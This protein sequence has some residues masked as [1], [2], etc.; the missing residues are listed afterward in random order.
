VAAKFCTKCRAQVGEFFKTCPYD[1]AELKLIPPAPIVGQ[2]F[3]ERYEILSILGE[4]GMSI[5]YKARHRFMERIVAIKLLR[6]TM[7]SDAL[8]LERFRQEA[9]AV[10]LLN[11]PNIVSVYDFGIVDD[12]QPFLVMDYLDGT[13]LA[14]VLGTEG[15]LTE[16]R[17]V[18][19]FR[20]ICEGLRHAHEK[21][22]VHRDL[23][24]TNICLVQ[25]EKKHEVAKIVD[26]GVAKMIHQD[27]TERMQLTQTGQVVGSPLFMSPEQC[28]AKSL[29]ARSDIYSLGCVMYFTLTGEFPIS[30]ITEFDAMS[31]HIHETPK[32]FKL[33][34]SQLSLDQNL[35]A[36][37]F[38]CLEKQPEDRYQSVSELLADLPEV[39]PDT[40]SLA[41]KAVEHPLRT[42]LRFRIFRWGFF[43]L[44]G[45]VSAVLLYGLNDQ[46]PEIDKGSVLQKTIWNSKTTWGQVLIDNKAWGPAQWVLANAEKQ[47]RD[48]FPNHSRL[49]TALKLQ[50]ELYKKARMFEEY[51]VVS[52]EIAKLLE[53]FVREDYTN[54]MGEID[55]LE[56]GQSEAVNRVLAEYSAQNVIHAAKEL[57]GYHLD[58]KEE[59]LLNRAKDVYSK[60]LGPRHRLIAEFDT[61]LADCHLR[62][63]E[64]Y[65]VRPLLVEARSIYADAKGNNDKSTIAATLRLGQFDR[66]EN[67]FD[68]AKVEL[69]TALAKAKKYYPGNTPD[70]IYLIIQCLNSYADYC[71][72]TGD[73]Q[74]A[75][76][77]F[78]EAKALDSEQKNT[79]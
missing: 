42:R 6:S 34:A 41:V 52:K 7:I 75:K 72:Q 45:L 29:D 23:K 68:L 55:K 35:E 46:G 48:Q 27:G 40:G 14:E 12:V 79:N 20:Q 37:V 26:F 60:L 19:I 2:I 3:A 36:T 4:G 38:R 63:Q 21:G 8:S 53:D 31:K 24:P 16:K 1:G 18:R 30:G 56:K 54:E 13:T 65:S 44:L 74:K 67:Q 70:D 57:S 33:A 50:R 77:L 28:S 25:D 5:V 69:E 10:S 78:D 49:L 71:A 15:H 64:T 61:Y 11:H 51:D 58:R 47:A 76:Q 39:A 59:T 22:I 43:L 73:K 17:A 9:Q 66:D 32:S 62:E